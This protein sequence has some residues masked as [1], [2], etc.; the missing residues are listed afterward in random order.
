MLA[1]VVRQPLDDERHGLL[2]TDQAI[3]ALCHQLAALLAAALGGG[4]PQSIDPAPFVTRLA[5]DMAAPFRENAMC[6]P[7]R[8]TAQMARVSPIR[9]T[10]AWSSP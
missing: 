6:Q 1:R 9:I 7:G 2:R 3:A 10:Q 5:Q 4:R 8:S